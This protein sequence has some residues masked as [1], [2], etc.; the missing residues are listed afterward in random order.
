MDSTEHTGAHTRG[1]RRIRAVDLFCGVGGLTRGMEDAGI[2]VRLDIDVDPA[3]E[4]PYA[5]NNEYNK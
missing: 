3:C 4:Y 2:D 5:E 1:C